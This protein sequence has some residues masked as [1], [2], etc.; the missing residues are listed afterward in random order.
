MKISTSAK[1][2]GVIGSLII[3]M[4]VGYGYARHVQ[5]QVSQVWKQVLREDCTNRMREISGTKRQMYMPTPSSDMKIVTEKQTLQLKKSSTESL[6]AEEKEFWADQYYL[7]INNPIKTEKLDSLFRERLKEHGFDLKTAVFLHPVGD[8]RNK[9]NRQPGYV[10]LGYKVN[11]GKDDI[12]EGYVKGNYWENILWGKSYYLF[13]TLI[14]LGASALLV[15]ERRRFKFASENDRE[16]EVPSILSSPAQESEIPTI[17]LNEKKH[18]LKYIDQ[19]IVLA[20]KVF[21]LFYLLSGGEDYFQP[22]D[23][24]LQNLWSEE[25]KAEKTHLEQVVFRLRKDLKEIPNL[26]IEAIWGSG[27]RIKWDGK[28]IKND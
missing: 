9:A 8:I 13:L 24:L 18:T 16:V 10:K 12:L 22:H 23:F 1:L 6:S 4:L 11:I 15:R 5:N 28:I 21:H 20:P 17:F 27:F 3:A 19:V 14:L 2:Y 25:E 26:R 7:S